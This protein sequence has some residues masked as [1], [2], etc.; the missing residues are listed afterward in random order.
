MY[1]S[2]MEMPKPI[3]KQRLCMSIKR[4]QMLLIR[5]RILNVGSGM[6]ELHVKCE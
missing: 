4:A 6:I 2:Q 3:E 5:V 1:K